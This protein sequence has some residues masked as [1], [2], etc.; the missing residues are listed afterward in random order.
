MPPS[1]ENSEKRD[2][3]MVSSALKE[4]KVKV[5]RLTAATPARAKVNG[6]S[7]RRKAKSA[8]SEQNDQSYRRP[9]KGRLEAYLEGT[10][11]HPSIAVVECKASAEHHDGQKDQTIVHILFLSAITRFYI[12]RYIIPCS[13]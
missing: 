7:E 2:R 11:T 8:D 12:R 6:V 1:M 13:G 9:D 4:Q 10:A 5:R 3:L